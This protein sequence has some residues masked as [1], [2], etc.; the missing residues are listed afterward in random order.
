MQLDCI[1]RGF[2][3]FIIVNTPPGVDCWVPNIRWESD[4]SDDRERAQHICPPLL[5]DGGEL[6][7]KSSAQSL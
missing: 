3:E 2:K 5:G 7:G 4:P 1:L 6:G